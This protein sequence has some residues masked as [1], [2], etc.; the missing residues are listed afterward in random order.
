SVASDTNR[1]DP[2][3]P[4][5]QNAAV[6]A[7]RAVA[8]G[9]GPGGKSAAVH[10]GGV[11]IIVMKKKVSRP[12]AEPTTRLLGAASSR[13]AAREESRPEPRRCAPRPAGVDRA[14]PHAG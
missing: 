4:L 1:V 10:A 7:N 14:T 6:P 5:G 13:S 12:L 11:P 8:A 9:A 2:C 3:T